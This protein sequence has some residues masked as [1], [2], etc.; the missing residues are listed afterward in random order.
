M[1]TGLRLSDAVLQRQLTSTRHLLPTEIPLKKRPKP[2]PDINFPAGQKQHLGDVVMLPA[3]STHISD[4][5]PY[6]SSSTPHAILVVPN[7]PA[8]FI[9]DSTV[10][11]NAESV[12]NEKYSEDEGDINK[13]SPAPSTA[14]RKSMFGDLAPISNLV[15]PDRRSLT[16][17]YYPWDSF[18]HS[19]YVPSDSH[20]QNPRH[21]TTR[22]SGPGLAS[23]L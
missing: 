3:G 1:V 21:D 4:H 6:F 16:P 13:H 15:N 14:R 10:F 11:L 7:R 17:T 8:Q 18:E 2:S 19:E 20:T 23:F 5:P 9:R 22:S 12:S